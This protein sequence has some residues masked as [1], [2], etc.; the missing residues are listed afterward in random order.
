MDLFCKNVRE[1]ILRISQSSGHG[2][3]PTCFSIIEI[4]CALYETMRHDP[5]RPDWSERDI[6]ILS[7]GHAALGLYCTLA[8]HDYFPV[9]EVLSFG[10]FGSNFGCHA[11]RLK[12]PGIEAS[13]GSLGHGIGIA[14]GMALGL[15]IS[16]SRRKVF[17]LVGDGEA[18]EGTVWEAVMVA[19]NRGLNNLTIIYDNNRSH[20]RGLQITDPAAQFR[21]FG[22][23]VVT[24]DGHDVNAVKEALNR[25]AQ[26][27]KV[28]V[29][30]TLKGYG[31]E[32][33]SCNHYEWHRRS[34]DNAEL[35]LL[36]G[37]LNAK[38]V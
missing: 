19:V 29:A 32:T 20:E 8:Y 7:K 21:G 16:D 23:D 6:F 10:K 17:V 38:T 18:N 4:L 5:K 36:M 22:C 14:V 12:V 11:D 37:E 3:I 2:H 9:S 1:T 28:I 35:A 24:A 26:G 31:C 34:P 25:E 33:L 15:K 30:Q 27:V 13:T